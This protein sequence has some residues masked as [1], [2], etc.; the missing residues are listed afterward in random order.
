MPTLIT[1][2][3]G[4]HTHTQRERDTQGTQDKMLPSPVCLFVC[5]FVDGWIACVV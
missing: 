5:L 3:M 4:I 1:D 2:I